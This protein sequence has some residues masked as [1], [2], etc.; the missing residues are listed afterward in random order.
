[1]RVESEILKR[2]TIGGEE[3]VPTLVVYGR[4]VDNR[5]WL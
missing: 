4:K 3:H 5:T 1:V 2:K